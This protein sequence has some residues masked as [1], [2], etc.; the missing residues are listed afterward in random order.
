[1][2]DGGDRS[3]WDT[4]MKSAIESL[5]RSARVVV[6]DDEPANVAVLTRLLAVEGFSNVVSFTDSPA[7]AEALDDLEAIAPD[8]LVLDLFMPPPDGFAVLDRVRRQ[9]PEDDYL[10]VLVLT[11]DSSP[12]AKQRALSNGANDFLTK[13]FDLSEAVLRIRNLLETRVL[14][15]HLQQHSDALQA[16]LDEHEAVERDAEIRHGRLTAEVTRVLD[17][18]GLFMVFQPIMRLSDDVFTGAEALSRFTTEPVRS[19]ETWF[20]N[21]AEIGRGVE[22]ELFAIRKAVHEAQALPPDM[23][24][25][26]NASPHT[27]LHRELLPIVEGSARPMVVELTEHEHVEDYAQLERRL[28]ELRQLGARIAVDDTGTGYASLQHIL[29]LHPELIKL[30]RF[31]VT[32]IDTDPVRRGLA[33]ALVQFSEDIGATLVAEGIETEAELRVLRELGIEHGQ[34]YFIARPS[35]LPLRLGWPIAAN[36]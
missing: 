18:V 7:A 12:E 1:M 30:D 10:P 24:L 25:S 20:A 32:G 6:V 4:P 2:Q 21:A 14:H 16:R 19:P 11:A 27:L 5:I 3:G 15:V 8:L 13:P 22:L 9:L 34:G 26:V 28:G 36:H 35:P 29:R 31:F 23:F 33:T 17:G